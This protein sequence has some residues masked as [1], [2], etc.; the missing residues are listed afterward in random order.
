MIRASSLALALLLIALPAAAKVSKEEADKLKT[1]LMPMGGEKAGNKDGSIPAWDGGLS[2]SP[3]CYKGVPNRLCDPYAEDKALFT[4]TAQNVAQ[5]K[6][7]LTPGQLALFKKYPDTFKM[8]VFK[9][10]RT[11]AYPDWV[12]DATYQNA[13]NAELISGGN[14]IDKS[15]VSV[16]FPI[17]KTGVD[18]IWNHKI[19]YRGPGATRY[20]EQ[21]AITVDGNYNLVRLREDVKFLYNQKGMTPDKLENILFYFFQVVE[22][23][24]RLAGTITLVHETMDQ[25]KEAR[26]AWQYNP[27]QRRLRR[28]PNVGYDN[29]G[30]ASDGLRTNDELDVFNGAPDRYTWKII[31]KKE[32]YIPYNAYELHS[33][34]Y[35]MKDL[36]RKGHLNPDPI[37]YELHRVWITEANLRPGTTHLY[38][39][40]VMYYDEDSWQI[41][42]SDKYD[43]RGEL[44]RVHMAFPLQAY[45]KPYQAPAM[46]A[47]YDLI[48]G[49]YLAYSGNNESAETLERD[50]ET[51]YFEPGNVQKKATK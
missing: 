50:F 12:Y 24:P 46:E 11:S 10:R 39:R 26:R 35:K 23:P 4:I 31:G 2:T 17:P 51:S 32:I 42:L 36:V 40:R 13:L 19:R 34:K 22:Q 48:S 6:D 49:R 28:A 38:A 33:D 1:T 15:I 20:N 7:K 25:V 27:G 29:P 5:Y 30:T 18:L 45:D 16:P 41:V 8:N 3:P 47:N 14:G 37:R 9:T 21:A 44:W 43:R